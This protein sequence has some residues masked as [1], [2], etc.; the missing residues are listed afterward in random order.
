MAG[1]VELTWTL[2]SV[3]DAG[4]LSTMAEPSALRAATTSAG[5][6]WRWAPGLPASW[7]NR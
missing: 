1:M 4:A 5:V 2:G 3:A 6:P 7:G